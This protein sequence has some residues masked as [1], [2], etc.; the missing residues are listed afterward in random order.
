MATLAYNYYFFSLF[1]GSGIICTKCYADIHR[2]INQEQRSPLTSSNK[3]LFPFLRPDILSI[4]VI[5]FP[6]YNQLQPK[7]LQCQMVWTDQWFT[8]YTWPS[9]HSLSDQLT[10]I[11]RD[12]KAP[13][14]VVIASSLSQWVNCNVQARGTRWNLCKGNWSCFILADPIKTG[15]E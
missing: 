15:S 8:N 12:I 5:G 14:P 7:T 11:P 10:S 6:P 4:S 9:T 1:G 13:C 3:L 2:E